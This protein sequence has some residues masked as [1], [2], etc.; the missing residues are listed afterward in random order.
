MPDY[1][2]APKWKAL[3]TFV[4]GSLLI[5]LLFA[6]TVSRPTL[7]HFWFR[8]QDYWVLPTLKM[9]LLATGLFCLNLAGAC[10][11]ARKRNWLSFSTFRFIVGLVIIATLPLLTWMIE[12]LPLFMQFILFRSV[13]VVLVSVGLWVVTRKWYWGIAS[14]MLVA[15]LA[16]PLFGNLPYA[17]LRSVS[18]KWFEIS[19]FFVGS[20]LLSALFGYWL[21]KAE[22]LYLISGSNI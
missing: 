10:L 6:W 12:P 15:S 2:I 17:V 22:R 7:E 19:E 11:I 8:Y 1:Q 3:S 18:P 5:G 16:T 14:L 13:L 4:I 9:S 20:L 21:V